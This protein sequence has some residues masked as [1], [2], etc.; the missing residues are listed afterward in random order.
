MS[1]RWLDDYDGAL[2][3]AKSGRRLLFI[4]FYKTPG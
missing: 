2:K 1:I 4:D 3:E